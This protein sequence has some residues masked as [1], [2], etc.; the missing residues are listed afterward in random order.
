MYVNPERRTDNKRRAGLDDDDEDL[1]D[2]DRPLNNH[3]STHK[4]GVGLKVYSNKRN[5]P[6]VKRFTVT[7]LPNEEQRTWFMLFDKFTV[8]FFY[9]RVQQSGVDLDDH[10]IA[11]WQQ[12]FQED[13]ATSPEPGKG[14]ITAVPVP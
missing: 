1:L 11:L 4:D 13:A 8:D 14:K 6:V 9:C 3:H 7:S 5:Y 10:A 12:H 2:D